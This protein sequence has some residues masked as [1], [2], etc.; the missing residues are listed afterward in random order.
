MKEVVE[1]KEYNGG[2][3]LISLRP[4][5]FEKND[6]TVSHLGYLDRLLVSS[7]IDNALDDLNIYKVIALPLSRVN[8]FKGIFIESKDRKTLKKLYSDGEIYLEIECNLEGYPDK[9]LIIYKSSS[10]LTDPNLTPAEALKRI[11]EFNE[12]NIRNN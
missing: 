9:K 1:I 5:V 4:K 2:F 12:N 8:N 6:I 3:C 7:E 10:H 11:Q